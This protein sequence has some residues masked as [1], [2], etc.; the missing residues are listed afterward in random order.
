MQSRCVRVLLLA[1]LLAIS[2]IALPPEAHATGQGLPR[3]QETGYCPVIAAEQSTIST[4]SPTKTKPET[5]VVPFMGVVE[6]A[7]I[8]PPKATP[9]IQK[10]ETS[11]VEKPPSHNPD[12]LMQM[13][14]DHRKNMGLPEF[15][16]EDRL[17]ALAKERGPE[18]PGEAASGA[19]HA[20]FNARNLPYWITE[21]MKYGGSEQDMFNWWLN[22]AIHRRAIEGDSQYSCGECYGDAC[23]QLFTSYVAK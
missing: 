23:I 10:Q 22:S 6:A 4:S 2:T 14:N 5:K 19:I 15:Q 13:I 9:V 16:K 17:C 18:L 11:S 20:G 3:T 7:S 1:I 12:L 8:E 21:N